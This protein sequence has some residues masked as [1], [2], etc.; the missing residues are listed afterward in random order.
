MKQSVSQA[1]LGL[2]YSHDGTGTLEEGLPGKC[3]CDF[4]SPFRKVRS[5]MPHI[6]QGNQM[7]GLGLF[8]FCSRILPDLFGLPLGGSID[9]ASLLFKRN[10]RK[11]EHFN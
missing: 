7:L 3:C 9:S 11:D 1:R 2:L 5:R 4:F 6:R 10:F 8:F